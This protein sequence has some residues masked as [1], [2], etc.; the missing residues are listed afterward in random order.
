MKT[1]LFCGGAEAEKARVRRAEGASI[2]A[3]SEA[4]AD[5]FAA[6][7]VEHQA[8]RRLLSREDRDAADEAAIAWTRDVGK[9]PLL[10]GRS[11]RELY[12]WKGVSLW[13]F[14]ELFLHHSTGSPRRVRLIEAFDRLL[15]RLAPD[16]VEAL[17][18]PREEALLLSRTCTARGI[19]FHDPPRAPAA[20]G[21]WPAWRQRLRGRLYEWKTLV[22]VLKARLLSAPEAPRG[23][24]RTPVLFLSHAAFWRERPAEGG[25]ALGYEHYFD[26][27][28][29]ETARH[30]D[31]EPVVIAV[32]PRAAFRRRGARERLAEWL[33]IGAGDS[34]YRHINRYVTWRTLGAVRRV[35]AEMRRALDLLLGSPALQQAFSHR[36]ARFF[37]LAAPDLA[38][39]LLLQIP[40]AVRSYEEMS[41]ALRATRPGVVCLYAE[42][43]GWG[44]A[45]VAACRAQGVPTL[46][47]QHGILYPTYYSYRHEADEQDCPRPDRTAVFGEAARRFLILA[48]RYAPES[49]VV[50]GSPKFDELARAARTWD[51]AAIRSR[52]GLA[53]DERLLAVASRFRGIRETHQSIGSAFPALVRAVEAL[54]GVRMLVKPHP[55]ESTGAYERTIREAAARRSSLLPP[56]GDL[57]QLLFAAD[58]LVTVES[59]SAVEA[60]VLGKPVVI[61]NMPTNLREMVEAGVAVGVDAGT[62]PRPALESVLGDAETQRRLA[63]ARR[64]YLSDA[65]RGV[66]GHASERLLALVLET[67]RGRTGKG[68]IEAA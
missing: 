18:M 12:E 66:D 4:A 7:G 61:L 31:L 43:S 62:D 29:P 30:Q 44:R 67:A 2:L 42:S 13:W 37:D 1:L 60:L 47:I 25:G 3:W 54:P 33:S 53:P 22:A 63:E 24:A 51:R 19:L 10:D 56:P 57:M 41:E 6:A 38:G 5:A 34:R 23:H 55:A 40:W 15:Q 50:T 21:L 17:G 35:S 9:R 11:L 65:A 14:A 16:E 8:A 45:A 58:A 64:A 32:G 52:L 46:G 48:G 68:P 27:L 26:Q 28:I 49:L 39:T 20:A 36:G 59:L